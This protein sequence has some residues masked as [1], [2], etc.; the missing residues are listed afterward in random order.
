MP[1]LSWYKPYNLSDRNHTWRTPL[2]VM[3]DKEK[4]PT[5]TAGGQ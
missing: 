4:S 3:P 2:E 1:W 5:E